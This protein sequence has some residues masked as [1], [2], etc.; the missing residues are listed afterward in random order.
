LAA[1]IPEKSQLEA[2]SPTLYTTLLIPPTRPP[3]H[4]Y[5]P[6]R[7]S[8]IGRACGSYNSRDQPQGR[9]FEPHLRLFLHQSSSEQL[10]FCFLFVQSSQQVPP[11]STG[12]HGTVE[13][14]KH[15]HQVIA[16]QLLALLLDRRTIPWTLVS[17]IHP[18]IRQ[19]W[20]PVSDDYGNNNVESW[21]S[22]SSNEDLT[23]QI[24]LWHHHG[25]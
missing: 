20:R 18:A 3:H 25:N 21:C 13:Y 5:N 19:S 6:C 24:L 4:Q 7:G 16:C 14:P 10:F 1:K 2:S 23:F 9:G 22:S 12:M 17:S 8:S 15:K 11:S